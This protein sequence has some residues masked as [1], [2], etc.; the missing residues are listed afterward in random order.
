MKSFLILLMLI[1]GSN[2]YG[3][4]DSIERAIIHNKILNKEID[5]IEYSFFCQEWLKTIKETGKYP[6]L[7]LEQNGQVH[8]IFLNDFKDLNKEKLYNR[9][10]EWLV[11]RYGLVASNFYSNFQDGR[12][13]LK[14][15]T[16]ISSDNTCTYS[17]VISIKD[18]KLLIEFINIGYQRFYAGYYSGDKWIAER[19][20]NFNINNV[21]PVILKKRSEWTDNLILLRKTNEFFNA[22]SESLFE[23]I[24]N[25][26]STFKF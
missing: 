1:I 4:T 13:I 12:I 2:L 6:D 11:I 21:Y 24:V 19:T 17:S 20:L 10:L 8:Y 18:N 25:Y 22:E 9:T 15:G 16:G 3:Q 5:Q 7:P 14:G 26:D 23:Y